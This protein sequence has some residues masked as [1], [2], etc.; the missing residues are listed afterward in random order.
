MTDYSDLSKKMTEVKSPRTLDEA[1]LSESKRLAP[2]PQRSG[3]VNWTTMAATFCMVGVAIV[4]AK[5]LLFNLEKQSDLES[6][7]VRQVIQSAEDAAENTTVE[8][9]N[10]IIEQPSIL[11][12]ESEKDEMYLERKSISVESLDSAVPTMNASK[13]SGASNTITVEKKASKPVLQKQL[14]NELQQSFA[15]QKPAS[16]PQ[17]AAV[18]AAPSDQ[19]QSLGDEAITSV[20]MTIQRIKQLLIADQKYE[21]RILL[22]RLKVFCPDC[23]IPETIEDIEF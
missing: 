6:P 18:M 19:A 21:A 4:V 11:A 15:A 1:I 2:T 8:K 3:W 13:T 14:E 22:S 20:E 7:Q 12:E 10:I 5:P 9:Q 23:E 16:E 17:S